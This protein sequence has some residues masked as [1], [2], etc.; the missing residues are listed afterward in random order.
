MKS[1][2]DLNSPHCKLKPPSSRYLSTIYSNIVIADI[3]INTAPAPGPAA[4]DPEDTTADS[5][6]HIRVIVKYKHE[7]QNINCEI[8][9]VVQWTRV[10]CPRLLH[11]AS[12][13]NRDRDIKIY[14]TS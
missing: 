6:R 10:T 9:W 4:A 8:N 1:V 12:Y 3:N 7:L 5:F 13:H 14:N 2:T 11:P